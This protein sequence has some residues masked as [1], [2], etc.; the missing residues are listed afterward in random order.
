MFAL[1]V[2]FTIESGHEAQVDALIAE[3]SPRILA[4]EPGT[5]VYAVCT[6]ASRPDVRVFL[7]VYRD[8]AAHAEHGRQPYVRTFLGELTAHLAKEVE[9]DALDV[10]NGAFNTGSEGLTP[11]P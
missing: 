4:E 8:R 10:V 9:V 11:R 7:E 1:H 6:D 2:T 3:A 5:L